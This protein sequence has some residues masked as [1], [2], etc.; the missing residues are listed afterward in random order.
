MTV[1]VSVFLS[2]FMLMLMSCYYRVWNV[3]DSHDICVSVRL[4][5]GVGVCSR[6]WQEGLLTSLLR[7]FCIQPIDINYDIM[8]K[9]TMKIMQLDGEVVMC[10]CVCVCVCV[11]T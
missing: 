8:A 5:A 2:G 1:E 6:E 7:K 9:P 11:C 4:Y 3:G 10:V